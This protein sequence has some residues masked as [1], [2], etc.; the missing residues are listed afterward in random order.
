MIELKE[1]KGK[2]DFERTAEP[3]GTVEES[4]AGLKFVIQHHLASR[5]H[6]DLRLEWGGVL[7]SWAIPKGPSYNTKDRRLAV[8]VEDHPLDYRN[9]E[10]TI[11]KGEYG[12]GT[13]MIWDEGFWE[14]HSNVD[15][16]IKK[17]ELKMIL[18]GS[19]LKGKWALIRWK[20]KSDDKRENW[21]L[22]KERDEYTKETAGIKDHTTSIRTGRTVKEIERGEDGRITANPFD[23]AQVQLARSVN[24]I[25]DPE[26]GWVYELKYDG[27]RIISYIECGEVRLVTRND[28]DYTKR[29]GDI[30]I[31]LTELASGRSMVL[32]GE[33]AVIDKDGRSDFH[34][35]QNYMRNPKPKMLTYI[36][37]DIL[38]LDGTDLR[39][40]PLGDRKRILQDLMQDAPANLFYS[41]HIEGRGKES[42][43][44]ACDA[45]TEGIIG[46][47]I[48][49]VYSGTRNGDWIKLKCNNM[50][51]FVIGGYTVSDKRNRGVSSLLLGVYENR[52]LMYAGR[53]GTGISEAEMK[54]L[55]NEFRDIKAN[56]SPFKNAPKGNSKEKI[57]W[58]KPEL[59]ALIRFAEW[60]ENNLLRHASYKGLRK[61]KAPKD[62]IKEKPTHSDEGGT[63]MKN[64]RDFLTIEGVKITN[65]DKIIFNDPE[66]TKADIVSYYA[67]VGERMLPYMENRILSIIRCPKG[68]AQPCFYKKH[69]GPGSKKVKTVEII[70]SEGEKDEYFYID[71]IT[72]LIYEAQMGTLEF[73]TWGSSIDTIERPDMM[74]FDLDPDENMNID[75]VRQGAMDMK[76][77]LEE[78]SLL[79]Y[80][81][82]SGGKGYHV[83]VP[84]K[85][86]ATWETFYEFARKVAEVMEKKWPDL[87]TS[88]IRKIKRKNRIFID[89]LRNGRGATSISPYS[90]RARTGA[91]VSMPITWDELF[92]VSPD[93]ITMQ[94]AVKRIAYKDPWEGF[95]LNRQMLT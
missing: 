30:E 91:R 13:V 93:E 51:E 7:L 28:N 9:F 38:A 10:G 27:Y 73:H 3:E 32:D 4:T 66:I 50:Q 12:G 81:K 59:V 48:D 45:G 79:S 5:D 41:R 20:A 34:S 86:T 46:K 84:L 11:P 72:G 85:P 76:A 37:F 36:I 95:F 94:E 25:P 62:V 16:A 83:V 78:L 29:F 47:R 82:T 24:G 8:K 64:N 49:S 26:G 39:K 54:H 55:E 35:L 1:Y 31:A 74:V 53:A 40:E 75:R 43:K 18:K 58:L 44:A 2:R 21:L 23:T 92:T 17:G 22:L 60:T 57:I 71:D 69:P 87:Y 15:E 42:L 52:E 89:W 88:N 19:R 70:N 65:P 61:D 6:Y 80:I 56:A 33:I 63:S 90:I 67:A 68:I 77:I 14:P